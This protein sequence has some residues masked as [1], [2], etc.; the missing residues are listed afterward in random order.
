MSSTISYKTFYPA[1][2][3]QPARYT[4]RCNVCGVQPSTGVGRGWADPAART[5]AAKTHQLQGCKPAEV[6][7]SLMETAAA[8]TGAVSDGYATGSKVAALLKAVKATKDP[9]SDGDV[10]RWYDR[11]GR[12]YTC[13]A[14]KGG[15]LWWFSGGPSLYRGIVGESAVDTRATAYTYESLAK[16]LGSENVTMVQLATGW[17]PIS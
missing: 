4:Y 1:G 7:A 9:F 13:S 6:R 14:L 2:Q 12:G 11:R 16:I 5:R 8:V 15:G 3:T 17:T 10:I